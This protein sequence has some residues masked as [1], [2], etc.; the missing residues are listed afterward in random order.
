MHTRLS[1]VAALIAAMILVGS[2]VAVGRLLVST[3]PIHFASMIRFA[4]A[5]LVLIPLVMM[6]EGRFPRISGRTLAILA[7]QA[8]C[9]SFLFT[10]FLLGG[11]RLT[12]AA[13]A[14]VV[15]AATPAAVA[16]LG[17]LF[18]KERPGGRA[19]LGIC[20]TT[21][22]IA[23]LGLG[24][25]SGTGTNVLWGNGLVLCAVVFE[26]VFLLL[27]RAIA[28][29]LSPLAA[30][31]WVSVLGLAF[32]LLP[33][34]WQARTLRAAT[35][36]PLA[37]GE[38]VYY[39]LG[40]TAAAYMLWFYGVM[41]VDAATAGG[42]TGVMPVAALVFAAWLCDEQITIREIAGCTGVLAGIGILSGLGR[43]RGAVAAKNLPARS[44]CVKRKPRGPGRETR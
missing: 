6:L 16:L 24:Q 32:F 13:D 30:A 2:S 35:L 33:G 29:P 41:R 27:R 37:I 11:L 8:L 14:G 9:G 40:V 4:L 25:G 17:W 12:G 28:A 44:A 18:F 19:V 3:L 23:A 26:A 22:G 38:L 39:G 20:A 5:S 31:M 43:P 21:A 10:V 7:S 36:T 15:A 34:L 42:I 1:A